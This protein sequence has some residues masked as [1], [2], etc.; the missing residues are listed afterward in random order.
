MINCSQLRERIIIPA[1]KDIN[2]YS[3]E[4]VALIVSTAAQESLGGTYVA[5]T[6]GPAL[7]IFQCEPAT[8]H[9]IW[10]NYLSKHLQ[11][12]QLILN[13]CG[14]HEIPNENE[15]VWNLRYAAMICRVHYLRFPDSLPDVGNM[16]AL[17]SLYKLRYNTAKG[18]ATKEDFMNNY[19]KYTGA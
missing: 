10:D 16:N 5:Q 11:L 9:D 12:S 2:L 13:K 7:G 19:R 3:P 15:L 1:L 18:A 17:W 8:Y 4:A 14:F 6:K